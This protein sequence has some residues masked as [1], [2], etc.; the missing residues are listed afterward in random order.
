MVR[1]VLGLFGPLCPSFFLPEVPST[2]K[3]SMTPNKKMC[4]KKLVLH[5]PPLAE[6]IW[7]KNVRA[8][9]VCGFVM[10]LILVQ[11]GWIGC[12]I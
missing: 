6:I 3:S 12:A 11:M 1:I 10:K 8:I 5:T 2:T 9:A 4:E 7:V